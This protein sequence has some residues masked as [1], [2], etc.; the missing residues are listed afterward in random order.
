MDVRVTST[1]ASFEQLLDRK[2]RELTKA[3]RG[4]GKVVA[5]VGKKAIEDAARG[6]RGSMRFGKGRLKVKSRN[7]PR[8]DGTLVELY[9]SPAGA[10]TIAES[11]AKAHPIKPR[12]VRALHFGGDDFAARVQHPGTR[13]AHIW[14]QTEPALERALDDELED[15][16]DAELLD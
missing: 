5:K 16:F 7:K 11:G 10:W 14:S 1:G 8:P 9:G 6:R 12:R 3:S 15:Y 4:A 2:A 13:G